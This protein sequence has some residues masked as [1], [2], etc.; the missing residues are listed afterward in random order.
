MSEHCPFAS[1]SQKGEKC[2]LDQ[3]LAKLAGNLCIK[4]ANAPE[5]CGSIKAYDLLH[6]FFESMTNIDHKYPIIGEFLI[7]KKPRQF[8]SVKDVDLAAES[9]GT[10]I[11]IRYEEELMNGIIKV[12]SADLFLSLIAGGKLSIPDSLIISLASESKPSNFMQVDISEGDIVGGPFEK[13]TFE[14]YGDLLSDDVRDLIDKKYSGIV[15]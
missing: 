15:D 10:K 4:N 14:Y 6:H 11:P 1:E 9:V 2:N 8:N 7:T 5:I 12:S 3:K 13:G